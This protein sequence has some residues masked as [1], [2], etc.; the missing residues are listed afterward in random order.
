MKL[1]CLVEKQNSAAGSGNRT[2]PDH[3]TAATHHGRR[4][5][6]VVRCLERWGGVDFAE[7]REFGE[8]PHTRGLGGLFTCEGRQY[9][10]KSLR[11]HGLDRSRW[12]EQKQMVPAGSRRDEGVDRI[13]LTE[14][15]GE[16]EWLCRSPVAL[17]CRLEEK[18]LHRHGGDLG[19][20][21]NRGLAQRGN[22]HHAYA[23]D[24][25]RFIHVCRGHQHASR[26]GVTR[27]ERGGQNAGR[28]PQPPVER[29]FA[30][31]HSF[32]NASARNNAQR[33]ENG[34]RD[35]EVEGR[36]LLGERGGREV[37]GEFARGKINA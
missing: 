16:I 19:A 33:H 25:G 10:G 3:D 11:H 6:G 12:S 30:Q 1:G 21:V 23:L 37:D 31:Q 8:R 17:C 2:W 5:G 28:G 34:D 9:S 14:H 35:S 26:T 7:G 22:S 24:E 27:G 36:P 18:W 13:G 32:L 20:G 4:R 29:E 15:V